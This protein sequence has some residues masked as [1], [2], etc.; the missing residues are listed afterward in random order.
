MK[1]KLDNSIIFIIIAVIGFAVFFLVNGKKKKDDKT[2]VKQVNKTNKKAKKQKHKM[3]IP[4]TTPQ[5]MRMFFKEYDD[6]TGI[7]KIDDTHYS[8]C[9]EFSDI[10]FSKASSEKITAIFL[11][12]VNFLNSLNQNIHLQV[13]HCGIPVSTDRYKEDYIYTVNDNMSENEKKLA[14]EFNEAIENNLG[15]NKT[16]FCETRL[17]VITMEAEN[18][19]MAK[20]LFFQNQMQIE[21]SF[22]AF[23]SKVRRWSAFERMKMLY[24]TFNLSPYVLDYPDD[25]NITE[26][27]KNHNETVYDFLAPKALVDCREQDYI[28]VYDENREKYIKVMYV[29]KMPSSITPSFY[30]RI[31]TIEDANIIV[32]ENITPTDPAK[33]IK[34]IE[35]IISGFK[36]E[37]LTKIKRALKKGYDYEAVKDE[38]LEEGLADAENL[39]KALVKKKQKLF[40]KNILICIIAD[41]FDELENV[42]KKVVS[43]ASEYLVRVKSLDWQQLEGLQN[44]LPFG[45][46]TLQFQRSMTS[47]ATATSVPFNTKTL[48]HKNSLYYGID[49]F[50]KTMVCCDRKRLMNGNGCVLATSGAGKSFFIKYNLEQRMLR[51]PMDECCILDPQGE[52]APVIKALGGQIIEISTTSKTYINPF[53]MELQY[54]DEDNDPV[55]TKMEYILAFIESIVGGSGLTGEQKSIID[56]CSKRMYEQYQIKPLN[57][58]KPS[59]P[60]FYRELK[61]YN[62]EEAKNLVLILERYVQGGID[63][64]SRD[65]N[66]EI[67]NRLVCFDLHNLTSSMQTTGYLVV[68]EHIMN[69][70]AKNKHLGRN[71]WLDVDEFHILL[72]NQYSAEYLARMYKIGRKLGLLPTIITQN[73][74]DVLKSD[75]GCKILSNSEFAVILKQKPLDLAAICKIFD[76]SDEEASYCSSSAPA[77]QGLIIYGEDIVAFRNQVPKESYI[78][79]LNNTDNMA[80]VRG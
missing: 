4:K 79:S 55:K 32:T 48:I 58:N 9:Y 57:D 10:S 31:T 2:A 39:R 15:Y 70:V 63:I 47:E 19:E 16:T 14:I 35:K 67:N 49:I 30:N 62:E 53:D 3:E 77:G 80:I 41:S 59:F 69:R 71:T 76:I 17:L 7:M 8:V 74:S 1:I 38:K 45:Y 56:R 65:T 13:I 64:F 12:Y 36:T 20:D 25:N 5:I 68:L 66:V 44:V 54:V 46:N 43:S 6:K 72:E 40:K 75:E 22:S 24:N 51:Y 73:I 33:I 50:S 61:T 23:K 26:L 78:Y 60:V 34:R 21:E 29:N 27:A 18:F 42:S 28:S 37:R 52:Y 11:K